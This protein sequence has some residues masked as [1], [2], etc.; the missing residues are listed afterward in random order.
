VSGDSIVASV[1]ENVHRAVAALRSRTGSGRKSVEELWDVGGIKIL[2]PRNGGGCVG[3]HVWHPTEYV[4][5]EVVL[6]GCTK[7][8]AIQSVEPAPDPTDRDDLERWL[9]S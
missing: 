5:P 6:R 7:C 4:F 3:E 1:Y 2:D 9:G 8:S